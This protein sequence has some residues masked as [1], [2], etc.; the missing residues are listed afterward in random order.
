MKAMQAITEMRWTPSAL[1]LQWADGDPVELA[2]VWLRDNLQQDRDPGNG[3]R[4]T[5]VADLPVTPRIRHAALEGATVRIEWEH[6]E[7]GASFALDWLEAQAAAIAGTGTL[8]R[9]R[10]WL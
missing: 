2:S 9:P 1:T 4:L 7:G 8:R 5:D 3:Q 6:E 10:L